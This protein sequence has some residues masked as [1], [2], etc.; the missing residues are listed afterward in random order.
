MARIYLDVCALNRLMDDPSQERIALEA[1]AMETVFRLIKAG[2]VTWIA[3]SILETEL[4]KDPQMLRREDALAM[5]TYAAESHIP[6]KWAA[7]RAKLLHRLGYGAFD[8][9]HLAMA[10]RAKVDFLLT[11]DD[12]FLRRARRNLGAPSIRVVNP[13]D[14]LREATA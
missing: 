14:Y 8:A 2:R 12:R 4:R 7:E 10:E 11:T 1:D 5:L 13:L 3:S 6:D 9:L